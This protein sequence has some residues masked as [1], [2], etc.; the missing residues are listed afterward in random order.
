MPVQLIGALQAPICGL[1]AVCSFRSRDVTT[2]GCLVKAS[3]SRAALVPCRFGLLQAIFPPPIRIS[4]DAFIQ[5]AGFH[6]Q[7]M[8]GGS[9]SI[10]RGLGAALA[11]RQARVHPDSC[12]FYLATRGK[13]QVQNYKCGTKSHSFSQNK[14]RRS[15][16]P[17]QHS[18]SQRRGDQ[19]LL[20]YRFS[21]RVVLD[22]LDA[23]R[24]ARVFLH[25]RVVVQWYSLL[26]SH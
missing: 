22:S 13:P 23:C 12:A 8:H 9:E 21:T 19:I 16:A 4:G 18:S 25:I 14:L 20:E 6:H 26:Q 15:R 10:G 11:C 3:H 1:G 24:Q 17:L 7:C 2:S 5:I